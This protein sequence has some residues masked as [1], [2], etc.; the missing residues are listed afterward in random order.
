MCPSSGAHREIRLE[1]GA[2]G[3][4]QGTS[5]YK[6]TNRSSQITERPQIGNKR[7]NLANLSRHCKRCGVSR[8]KGLLCLNERMGVSL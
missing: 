4:A 3:T 5:G 2:H 8:Y 6:L 1:G 7:K